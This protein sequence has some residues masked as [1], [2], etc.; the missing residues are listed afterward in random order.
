MLLG[1]LFPTFG[2]QM[3]E[4]NILDLKSRFYAEFHPYDRFPRSK[5]VHLGDN[6]RTSCGI[7]LV[8]A[9]ARLLAY[10]SIQGKM[11]KTYAKP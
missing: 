3:Q 4:F 2:N 8:N 9:I 6:M 10:K 7:S 1:L 5:L 11:F